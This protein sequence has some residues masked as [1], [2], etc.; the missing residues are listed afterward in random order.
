MRSATH[1]L[2]S[3]KMSGKKDRRAWGIKPRAGVG[4]SANQ[5]PKRESAAGYENENFRTRRRIEVPVARAIRGLW[6]DWPARWLRVRTVFSVSDCPAASSSRSASRH[7]GVF[8]SSTR[9]SGPA[10]TAGN[11]SCRAE[12][13]G[14][15]LNRC[16]A[17]ATGG[18]V[19]NAD[20]APVVESRMGAWILDVE[21]QSVPVVG[22]TLGS[23][24]AHGRG[25]DSAALAAG[26]HIMAV[27]R[28]V[29]GLSCPDSV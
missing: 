25:L 6:C 3:L 28:R 19:G 27:L 18:A 2:F 16:H 21:K 23:A 22:R 12:S 9:G 13:R 26:R 5:P 29:L 10:R 8:F 4:S 15:K 11:G 1:C 24:A 7:H 17:A 20:T 14:R